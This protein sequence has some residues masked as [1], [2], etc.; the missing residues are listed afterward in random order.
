MK[1]I[2]KTSF[3]EGFDTVPNPEFE[4]NLSYQLRYM[5]DKMH[6]TEEGE[7]FH[8]WVNQM[9]L[10]HNFFPPK[11]LVRTREFTLKAMKGTPTFKEISR[12]PHLKGKSPLEELILI[13]GESPKV[14]I[15]LLRKA[16]F[17][18]PKLNISLSPFGY[19]EF[20][21]MVLQVTE[22]INCR[23]DE[24]IKK[25]SKIKE[26][27]NKVPN[28]V[29]KLLNDAKKEILEQI[30]KDADQH[31]RDKEV[32]YQSIVHEA[33]KIYN[34]CKTLTLQ[35]EKA[36]W[37]IADIESLNMFLDKLITV[38]KNE[39]KEINISKDG[40]S[41]CEFHKQ[42]LTIFQEVRNT[43]KILRVAE[44][45]EHKARQGYVPLV[46]Q[47]LII[48]KWNILIWVLDN[49]VSRESC[50]KLIQLEAESVYLGVYDYFFRK[51]YRKLRK[52]LTA[53]DQ[54][55]FQI[56]YFKRPNFLWRIPALDPIIMS[57]LRLD[58]KIIGLLK[59]L[60]GH[61]D[62]KLAKEAENLWRAFLNVY[63]IWTEIVKD[64]E[65]KEYNERKE[66]RQTISI[67]K[68]FSEDGKLTLEDRMGNRAQ[69]QK[70]MDKKW[71][72][73][74]LHKSINENCTKRQ[75]QVINLTYWENKTQE[76]IG[77]DLK[78]TQPTVQGHLDAGL[79]NIK[80]ELVNTRR[81]E[82]PNFRAI[83]ELLEP[84]SVQFFN[85][86]RTS[87]YKKDENAENDSL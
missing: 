47:S 39:S 34:K 27:Y 72:F 48:A 86:A 16:I 67:H 57:F 66:K 28:K 87:F 62:K 80:K 69:I 24:E 26:I 54:R 11:E 78:I 22:R 4:S 31:E 60:L 9:L 10:F 49:L 77:K 56:S 68:P 15:E 83:R 53:A 17:T 42:M 81:K 79:Q 58:E 29:E 50:F 19:F 85:P 59:P 32:K 73:A 37:E 33:Q 38:W 46:T 55:I 75:I 45:I 65:I 35:S 21:Q 41:F 12:F 84:D 30:F 6:G 2:N 74:G 71:L 44:T 36:I 70:E 61:K 51:A 63:P 82:F 25:N 20:R 23:V 1:E 18:L 5:L 43:D 14:T 76:M 3:L 40:L 8:K 64:D 13:A 7:N 52:K